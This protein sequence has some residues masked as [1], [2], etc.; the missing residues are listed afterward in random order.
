MSTPGKDVW[1]Y[2]EHL[3]GAVAGHTYEMLGKGRDIAEKMGCRLVAVLAGS[4]VKDLAQTLGAADRVLCIEDSGLADFTPLGHGAVL[5]ALAE[6][7]RPR[8]ILFGAT[9]MGMDLASLLSAAMEIPLAVNCNDIQVEDGRVIATAQMCG[10]KLLAEVEVAGEQVA[11][12]V[13]PGAFPSEKGVSDRPPTVEDIAPP[14]LPEG[15][16]MRAV[17]LIEP[18]A[19][20][21]DI[22]KAPVLVAVGRG[23][24]RKDNL[25]MAEDLANLLDGAV[26]AS[27]PVVDQGWLPMS[28]QV[29]KS[30]MI[31][32]PRL[33][34]ALGIS[35]APEHLEGMKDAELVIAVNSD[36]NAPIFNTADYGVV[37]DMFDLLPPLTSELEARKG[38]ATAS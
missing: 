5:R 9:S 4:S 37:A 31:V 30:G 36:P 17:R 7:E 26:C 21:V 25:P 16:R 20:D 1:V 38:Q 11:L 14:V 10:G 22:T 28:R 15:L 24:Q 33:Y 6:Q 23:I 8:L 2:V 19:G 12:T 32:K 3:Q 29:G 13:L 34:L 35:G 27:R 18:E